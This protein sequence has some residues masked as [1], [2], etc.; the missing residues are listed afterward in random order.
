MD[1]VGQSASSLAALVR[2]GEVTPREVVQAHLSRI[3]EIDPQVGAFER[4]RAINALAEADDLAAREDRRTAPL[5]GVPIAI[6][7]NL[8]VAGEPMR[9][10]SRATST[11]PCKED[12]PTVRRLRAAGAIVVGMTRVPEFCLWASTDNAFGITRNPWNL[13]RSSGGS[14]GGSAA[15]VA[16]AMVPLALGADGLGSIRIPSAC[17]GLV[18]LKPGPNV[19]P[20]NLG[21][22]AWFGMAENG[23]LATTVDDAA[24]ML[25]VLAAQPEFR[26]P[27]APERPL[28]IAVST[29]APLPGMAVD[30][31][32]IAATRDSG[33]LLAGAGHRVEFVALPP[34]PL[35]CVVATF[36]RWFG[37]PAEDVQQLD[38]QRL[39]PRTRTHARL[40]LIAR[41][42]GLVRPQERDRWREVLAPFFRR[43]DV[44][45]TPMLARPPKDAQQWSRR[46]WVA[47]VYTDA[48]Y[49]PFAASWNLAGYPAAA[50]PAG[51]H[52]DGM[53]L[54]VQ[55]VT[56]EG[57]E[58]L[59]LAVAKQLEVL[60]SWRR[61]PPGNPDGHRAASAAFGNPKGQR[62]ARTRQ[63]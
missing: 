30:S 18:G 10:G 41:K 2:S 62:Y 39:E 20:A 46:S 44:L 35:R 53:P 40:G 32:F 9:V 59:I 43:Y 48:C 19:V 15:A 57:G 1:L 33:T 55:L 28:R 58:K 36:A 16:S 42:F 26:D 6:K 7:D 4:V 25:S 14:S 27:V 38:F 49:A 37:G 61:H 13:S 60:R 12:H 22:S 56:P 51:V 5:A 21:A 31:E 50:I 63:P 54:S 47:N 52:S 23:P 3:A 24:L 34:L 8:P 17:C 45:I 11:T 29:R